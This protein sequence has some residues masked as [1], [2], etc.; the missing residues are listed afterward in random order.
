MNTIE[1]KSA[2]KLYLEYCGLKRIIL[3]FTIILFSSC[4]AGYMNQASYVSNKSYLGMPILEFKSIAGER[5]KLEVMES[6]YT[7]FKMHDYAETGPFQ[8]EI[9]DTKFFYFDSSSKL[10]KIDGGEFKQKRYQIEIL[11]K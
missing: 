3:I 7:V 6:G 10:V 1:I 5:A 2:I 8:K 11:N 9:V 4:K